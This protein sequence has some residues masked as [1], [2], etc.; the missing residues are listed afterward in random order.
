MKPTIESLHRDLIRLAAQMA[1][2]D[3][4]PSEHYADHRWYQ[5]T[6]ASERRDVLKQYARA[7]D[8]ARAWATELRRI[9]DSLPVRAA[10]NEGEQRNG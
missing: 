3:G 1:R 9:A 4:L 7:N 6:P 10:P 8:Q 2:G 5:T